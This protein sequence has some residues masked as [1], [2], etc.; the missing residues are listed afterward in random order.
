VRQR[1]SHW[2]SLFLVS[3]GLAISGATCTPLASKQDRRDAAAHDATPPTSGTTLWA[4]DFGPILIPGDARGI[5]TDAAG[6]VYVTGAFT[7]TVDFG[8]TQL[9]SAGGHDI[10]L[11]KYEP[12]GKL[13]FARR[14]GDAASFQ[15]GMGIAVGPTGDIVSSGMFNG[16]ADFGD[17]LQVTQGQRAYAARFLK[18][19]STLWS[20]FFPAE[21]PSHLSGH[22]VA[23]TRTGDIVVCGYAFTSADFGCGPASAPSNPGSNDPYVVKLDASGK[24]LWSKRSTIPGEAHSQVTEGVAVGPTGDILAVGVFDG[25]VDLGKDRLISAGGRDLFLIK[26][27][28]SGN[29]LWNRQWVRIP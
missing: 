17:G 13:L 6:F 1:F 24:C 7:G 23:V 25:S 12:S 20:R 21:D 8:G 22:H 19:G 2:S 15:L 3:L 28:A 9:T 26:F 16:G 5:A 29:V 18:D 11:A 4:R 10:V 14:F 27:D